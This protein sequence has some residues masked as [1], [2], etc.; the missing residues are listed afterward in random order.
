MISPSTSKKLIAAG[1]I[2]IMTVHYP[3]TVTF[4]PVV[5]KT[6]FGHCVTFDHNLINGYFT[7]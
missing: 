4:C 2:F 6:P 7:N 1:L 3:G 5:G